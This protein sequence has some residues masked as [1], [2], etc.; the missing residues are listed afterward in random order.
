MT[1]FSPA[2]GTPRIALIG[3]GAIAEQYYLPA[4]A[5]HPDVLDNLILVDRDVARAQLL[6]ERFNVKDCLADYHPALDEVDGAIV[7]LPTGLHH[8]VSM[9]FLSR[10]LHVLCEKPLA[11]CVDKARQMVAEAQKTGAVLATDYLQRLWPQFV[12]V[13]E[14]IANGVL[15]EPLSIKYAVGEVFNWPTV[16]G[17]YFRSQPSSRGVLRDRGAHVF[18]HICWWLGG[19]PKLIS[20]L[21]DSFG[22]SEATALVRFEHDKCVGEVA[23]SWLSS[24]PCKFAVQCEAG[25][26]EGDVYY[27]QD[28][29][30]RMATRPPKRVKLKS[31]DSLAAGDKMVT[32][33]IRVL[34]NGEKPLVAGSD[35][36]DSIEF[37]D[38]CYAAAARFPM[39]WYQ[40]METK[41]S[42]A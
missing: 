33:F 13:K 28:V 5:R 12:K 40:I 6:A 32:N 10:G 7:A 24:F 8:S 35:V 18:D 2:A 4:L 3:C 22:G 30:L 26:I 11:E 37:I 31:E 1:L 42:G 34:T 39:P 23:L 21:N 16:S 19:K 15:G 25:S 17:F 38:E 36:L 20:S 29:V 14:L 27:S 9:D 41:Q